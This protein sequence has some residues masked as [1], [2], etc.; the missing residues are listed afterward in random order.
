MYKCKACG[1]IFK[2]PNQTADFEGPIATCPN[3]D[4]GSEQIDECTL[5]QI[6]QD[7][8]ERKSLQDLKTEMI[9]EIELMSNPYNILNEYNSMFGGHLTPKDIENWS[10]YIENWSKDEFEFLR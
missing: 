6:N 2:T 3:P 10:E 1:D 5:E 4:C 7:I 9:G 8:L